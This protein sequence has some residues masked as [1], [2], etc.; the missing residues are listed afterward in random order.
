MSAKDG[1]TPEEW[2]AV[3]QAPFFISAAIGLS[4]P[5]GPFGIM[6]EGMALA[7]QVREAAEGDHGSLA[8]EV[9]DEIRDHRP[10]RDEL[11]GG[12]TTVDA[13]KAHAIAQIAWIAQIVEKADLDGDSYLAWLNETAYAIAEAG[14]EGGFLG[15]GGEAISAEEHAALG[16]IRVALGQ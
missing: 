16:Q 5:S 11:S 6:Q 1:F 9:A 3:A 14:T 4:D 2:D 13:A 7:R 12:A 15:F 8:K 10:G